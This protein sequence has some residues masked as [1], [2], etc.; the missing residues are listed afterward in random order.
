MIIGFL[1]LENSM[2]L[3]SGG[4]NLEGNHLFS[5]ALHIYSEAS[6]IG[7]DDWP[8]PLIKC[9]WYGFGLVLGLGSAEIHY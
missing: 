8:F 3:N 6:D 2:D 9:G 4:C 5:N 1:I 7:L